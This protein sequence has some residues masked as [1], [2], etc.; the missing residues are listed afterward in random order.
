MKL[1]TIPLPHSRRRLTIL[2]LA[3]S[4]SPLSQSATAA[5]VDRTV[6]ILVTR[7]G[8]HVEVSWTP[9]SA[10]P[11]EYRLFPEY[12]VQVSINLV[13][14][15]PT[16]P[17]VPQRLGGVATPITRRI[18]HN[19]PGPLF[20]RLVDRLEIQGNWFLQLFGTS[21]T[22]E[23]GGADLRGAKLDG[24]LFAGGLILD[25]ANLSGAS[26]RQA[27]VGYASLRGVNFT[28]ADV[29]GANFYGTDLTGSNFTR[30]VARDAMFGAANMVSLNLDHADL[31]GAHAFDDTTPGLRFHNTIMPDGT[32]RSD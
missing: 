8:D 25:G 15:S 14:W 5:A 27:P 9:K 4:F 17:S 30:V 26:L 29:T 21:D 12:Q 11:G 20:V 31:R 28:G 23:L 7:G 18:P 10:L 32:V 6:T 19:T 1:P 22:V 2:V 3:L 16:G 13:D 24:T